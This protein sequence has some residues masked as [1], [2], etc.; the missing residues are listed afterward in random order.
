MKKNNNINLAL[1]SPAKEGYSET[2]IKAQKDLLPFNIHFYYG[3]FI[4]LNHEKDGRL[5]QQ[6][7][8]SKIVRK[9]N[10]ESP[11]ISIQKSVIHNFRKNKINCV[12]AQYGPTG[13]EMVNICKELGIPLVVH[14]HGYDASMYE[15]LKSYSEKYKLMYDYASAIIVVSKFMY[16]ELVKLCAPKNKLILNTYGPNEIF[17]EIKPDYKSKQLIAIGRFVD[18]KAPYYTIL[19]FKQVIKNLPDAK[20]VMIGD[21][22]LW[23]T[24]KNLVHF[25]KLDNNIIF[26]GVQ[27]PSEIKLEMS[28]SCAFIQHSI[29]AEN[30]DCEGTPLSVLEAQLAGL[31]VISTYH[32][33]IPDVVINNKTGLLS[34]EHDVDSMT[35]HIIN[36]LKSTEFR[37]ELGENGKKRIINNFS[38]EKYINRLSEVI[39]AA[40]QLSSSLL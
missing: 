37:M 35:L 11:A 36:L 15:T 40:C 31:P 16:N 14:F 8:Y 25:Y 12:L 33:G 10:N 6:D 26:K 9:I 30:G 3:G 13:A 18:K 20:L 34:N 39:K 29:R 22:P 38:V 24:C 21:G 23:A 28:K 17:R 19:A 5:L 7:L 1:I 4:P 27:T 32:A 2:F